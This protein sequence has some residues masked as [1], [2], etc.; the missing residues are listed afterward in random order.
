MPKHR[1]LK[2]GTKEASILRIFT[3]MGRNLLRFISYTM[4]LVVTV[5]LVLVSGPVPAPVSAE[6][7]IPLPIIMYH[8]IL[9]DPARTSKYVATP[10]SISA[11]LTYLKEHGYTTVLPS[12]VIAYARGEGDLP[13]RPVMLTF[14]DGYL[15]NLL[16][17][18]ELLEQ[19]DACALVSIVGDYAQRFTDI[20][21]PNPNYAHMTWDELNELVAGGRIELGNHSFSMHYQGRRMGAMRI[22]GED[23]A[24]FRV[25]LTADAQKLQDALLRCCAITP[26]VYAYP[27]GF[28][29]RDGDEILR[30]MGFSMS[31]SC[32]EL[33]SRISRDPLSLW[34]LGRYNRAGNASTADFMK[35]IGIS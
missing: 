29:D 21:D 7:G 17:L 18:P 10:E 31:L 20:A 3:V 11:D 24:Q 1:I 15:N 5:A 27:Y 16:Y 30:D 8:S 35:K 23:D 19:H 26:A 4:V 9:R 6:A 2:K 22:R 32:Y 13:E 33:T 25:V 12:Q 14:D 34:S 28:I